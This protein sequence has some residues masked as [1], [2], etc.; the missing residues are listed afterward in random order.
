MVSVGLS[1]TA[2]DVVGILEDVIDVDGLSSATEVKE[3]KSGIPDSISID[4]EKDNCDNSIIVVV[5]NDVDTVLSIV[6]CDDA[7]D[8]VD[9]LEDV[10]DGDGLRSAAEVKEEDSWVFDSISIDADKDDV[11]DSTI[12]GVADDADTMVSVMSSDNAGDVVGILEDIIDIDRLPSA[13]EV[14]EE[15]SGVLDSISIDVDK[16]EG[17]NSIILVAA[18]DVDTVVSVVSSDTASDVLGILEDVIDID[19]LPSATEVKEENSGVLDS[20]SI[21]VDKD[22]GDNSSILVAADDVNTVVSIVPFDDAS[23]VFGILEDVIDA[24]GLPSAA[25]VIEEDSGAFDSASIDADKGDVDDSILLVVAV[26]A[27]TVVSVVSSD[28]ASDV[29]GILEDVIDVDGLP[30]AAEVKEENSGVL[31]S[32][33]IDV[34]KDDSDNSIIRIVADDVD[35]LISIISSDD[36]GDGVGILEDVI[37]VDGLP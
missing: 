23:D 6:Y 24:D 19:R 2:S 11:D 22:E 10:I 28:D 15:N 18:D 16:D 36:A 13:T 8:V 21:D 12:L 9:I 3:E 25:E 17:D 33:S 32:I 35:T 4:V 31:D 5:A 1:D 27:D 14:K 20:I 30:S 26:D 29:V 34:D 7:S 37:D